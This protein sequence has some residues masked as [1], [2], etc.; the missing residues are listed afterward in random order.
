MKTKLLIVL[1]LP[2]LGLSSCIKETI[3]LNNVS[4][5]VDVER[6]FAMPLLKASLTF[7]D[8]SDQEYDGLEFIG[9]DTIK[10]YFI[11]DISYQD[12]IDFNGLPFE[13]NN[14][15]IE[16]ANL[17]HKS[18]NMLPLG[19][20]LNL[21]LFNDTLNQNVDTISFN[22]QAG[23]DF[24]VAPQIN[25]N[26]LVIEDQ[27]ETLSGSLSFDQTTINNLFKRTNRIIIDGVVPE[28]DTLVKVLDYYSIDLDLGI[29]AKIRFTANLDSLTNLFNPFLDTTNYAL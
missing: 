15:T 19:L 28:T 2:L 8:F 18:R 1:I 22:D 21:F 4:R 3:Q 7:G 24:L 17:Y 26:G 13:F 20:R 5:D 9:S 25:S 14:L 29:S 6:S 16:Y 12:T 10:L 11:E 27:V 23:G